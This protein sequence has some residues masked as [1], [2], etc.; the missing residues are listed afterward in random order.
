MDFFLFEAEDGLFDAAFDRAALV[1]LEPRDR[2]RYIEKLASLL[3]PGA[4]ALLVTMEHDVGSG[5]PFSVPRDE[6]E[7]LLSGA[8]DIEE[9]AHEDALS[10]SP[11]LAQ[12]GATRVVERAFALTRRA[13]APQR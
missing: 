5:P 9:L 3:R 4:K 12:K 7:R 2:K 10:T 6:V 11:G 1:A 8:F 13:P